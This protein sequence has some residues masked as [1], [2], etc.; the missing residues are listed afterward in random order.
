MS[1]NKKLKCTISLLYSID[2]KEGKYKTKKA[3]N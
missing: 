2:L 1:E 3:V